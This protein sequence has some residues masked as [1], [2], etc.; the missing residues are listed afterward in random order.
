MALGDFI[1]GGN[2]LWTDKSTF[3][4]SSALPNQKLVAL[5][6]NQLRDALYDVRSTLLA[7]YTPIINSSH[8]AV[9]GASLSLSGQVADG[10]A[11]VGV[12]LDNSV[13][14]AN[15][16]AK[17]LSVR[18]N[19]AEK[20][21]VDRN[22]NV[23]SS[24]TIFTASNIAGNGFLGY[25]GAVSLTGQAADGAG[26]VGVVINNNVALVTTGAKIL[27]V[28]NNSVEKFSVDKDGVTVAAGTLNATGFNNAGGN[29]FAT[30][31]TPVYL[32]GAIA[33]S[34]TARAVNIGNSN[35]LATAGAKIASFW[36]DNFLTE[37][38]FFDL[39][40]CLSLN[41]G[42]ATSYATLDSTSVANWSGLWCIGSTARTASNY[43]FLGNASQSLFNCG[44]AGSV[45][46]R[47]ANVTRMSVNSDADGA[48]AVGQYINSP[49]YTVAGAKILS[50]QN[51]TVEKAYFDYTGALFTP[52]LWVNAGSDARSD[53]YYSRGA[54]AVLVSGQVADGASAVG[55]ALDNTILL[56]TAGAKLV[57][58]RNNGAEKAY[59]SYD[60]SFTTIAAIFVQSNINAASFLNSSAAA[61]RLRGQTADGAAAV[62]C[63]IS[64]TVALATAGAKIVSFYNDNEATEKAYVSKDGVAIT[65]GVG[66]GR[67]TITYSAS[68][69]PDASLA[70]M[71][72]I[73]ATNGTAFTINAPINGIDSQSLTIQIS[74]TSG[75]ALG[76]ATW[77]AAY[78]MAAWTQPATGFNRSITFRY[79]NTNWYEVYRSASDIPN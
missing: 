5:E 23:V 44:A 65:K 76:V 11:A 2:P 19:T 51:N 70:E 47:I 50:L 48:T 61:V 14:L 78:K 63:K 26:T 4:P 59:I 20:F 28:R 15:A 33:D 1:P 45:Q 77:N 29:Y 37:K 6:V 24:G 16:T 64:N 36:S 60:G 57:S 74:N 54:N 43:A 40:G 7:G 17:L 62:G 56:S 79:N 41:A 73:V 69:T 58:F 52:R 66:A 38:A 21:S 46:F 39:N 9:A 35:A 27:S 42:G 8:L 22:G 18:N 55:V 34:G 3:L 53:T 10:A 75:G 72:P 67:L 13:T 71:Q 30:S 25:N 31:G 49:A 68:M 32:R 12:V